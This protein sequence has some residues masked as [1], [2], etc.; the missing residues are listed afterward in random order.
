MTRNPWV[1]IS[2]MAHVVVLAVISLVVV[3]QER[4]KEET[5]VTS[6][7]IA[8]PVETPPEIKP[9]EVVDREQVPQLQEELNNQISDIAEEDAEQNVDPTLAELPSGDTTGGS[10]AGVSGPGHHGYA[11]SAFGGKKPGGGKFGSRFGSG[12]GG[13]KPTIAA[14]HDGLVWLQRHQDEDGRWDSDDFMKHDKTGEPCDGPGS[15]TV[16]VGLTGLA[17]LAFLGDGSTLRTGP[18]KDVVR[19]A[20]RWLQDQQDMNTGLIG[21]ASNQ[22]MM[23]CHATAA[24]ALCEAYGLSEY[25][26]LKKHAQAAIKYICEARNPTMVWRYQPQDGDNDTSVT[27]WMVLCLISAKEFGLEIDPEALT[28]SGVWLDQVT[29]PVSGR[30]G[31]T[32]RGELSSRRANMQT[33]FPPEKTES[34]TA[35][36]LLCRVFL[37][38]DPKSEVMQNAAKTLLT[39]PPLWDLNAGTID[40]YY[41]YYGSYA[42]YQIGGKQWDT[43]NTKMTD[44]VLRPQRSDG[45]AKGSWDP[46]DPWG[47]DGGRVYSTAMMVLCLEVY[48]RYGRVLGGR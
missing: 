39:R 10:A 44:A 34:M 36:G 17:L 27:G 22:D 48:Y 19:K 32:K 14:V 18:F 13:T 23:Y 24:L 31:Y 45:N 11:P 16:D 25:Q 5:S 41:W 9:P 15:A 28:Y 46:V 30:A 38:Q 4:K 37:G 33:K 47:E 12:R 2:F 20:V 3:T 29:D 1:I 6:V 8:P 42:L 35:V 43:W 40:M 7:S 26:P 21:T